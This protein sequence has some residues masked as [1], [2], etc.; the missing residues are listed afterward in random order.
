MSSVWRAATQHGV[1]EAS[2]ARGAP[3]GLHEPYREVDRGMVGHIHPENLRGAD[4]EGALR[5]RCVGR[6]TAIEQP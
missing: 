1:D 4:Q 5:P 3:I 2:I 6:D